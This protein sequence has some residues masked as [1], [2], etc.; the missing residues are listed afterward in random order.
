MPRTAEFRGAANLP[1]ADM[2]ACATASAALLSRH[3]FG[4]L[5]NSTNI[6]GAFSDGP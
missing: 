5:P 1:M 3:C 2:A 4:E 6:V